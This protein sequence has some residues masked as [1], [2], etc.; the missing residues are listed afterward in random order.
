MLGALHQPSLKPNAFGRTPYWR[1][2]RERG[3]YNSAFRAAGLFIWPP[4]GWCCFVAPVRATL[5][6]ECTK[7]RN[8][9]AVRQSDH[10]LCESVPRSAVSTPVRALA[11]QHN[12][13][14]KL[15]VDSL[16]TVQ[17]DLVG[18]VGHTSEPVR[19]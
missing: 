9:L 11:M 18:V 14:S 17:L 4:Y 3:I 7:W 16:L 8:L 5:R 19:V 1:A 12:Q 2:I 13:S 6:D 10:T 15:S